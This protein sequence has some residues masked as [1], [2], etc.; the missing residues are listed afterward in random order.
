MFESGTRGGGFLQWEASVAVI[1]TAIGGW[2]R[3]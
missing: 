3:Q 2:A 1:D